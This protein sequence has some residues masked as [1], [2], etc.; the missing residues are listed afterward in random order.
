[1]KRLLPL[2]LAIA[3]IT[4]TAHASA[5]VPI[6][7]TEAQRAIRLVTAEYRATLS[8]DGTAPLYFGRCAHER[9]SRVNCRAKIVGTWQTCHFTGHVSAN[10]N[11]VSVTMR[12]LACTNAR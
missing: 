3:A 12:E 9:R 8:R 7:T 11:L 6:T 4:G 1:M 5:P 10:S 2:A